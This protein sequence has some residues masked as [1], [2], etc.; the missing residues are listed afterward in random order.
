MLG[1]PRVRQLLED[2]LDSGAPQ[3]RCAATPPSCCRRSARAGGGCSP[4]NARV[5][6]LFPTPG[7]AAEPGTPPAAPWAANPPQVPGYEVQEV[8]GHG[9]MGRSPPKH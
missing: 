3:R 2:L 1:D 7:P 9:G 5:D 4:S 8:L 6:V